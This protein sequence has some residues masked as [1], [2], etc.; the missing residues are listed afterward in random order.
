MTA[1]APRSLLQQANDYVSIWTAQYRPSVTR[2]AAAGGLPTVDTFSKQPSIAL[3][4]FASGLTELSVR[5]N[6]D[7]GSTGLS[8]H[9]ANT[10]GGN[11][12]ATLMSAPPA[13]PWEFFPVATVAVLLTG[14]L[15]GVAA[16]L[17]V[18]LPGPKQNQPLLG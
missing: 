8:L 9:L 15:T 16:R 14:V 10:D 3:Q 7:G 11:A 12:T 6:R 5:G 1:P 17:F 4:M 13:W 2:Q 18:V